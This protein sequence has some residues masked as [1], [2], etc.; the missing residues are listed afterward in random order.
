MM[1]RRRRT[2]RDSFESVYS[3]SSEG[4][5]LTC[6]CLFPCLLRAFSAVVLLFAAVVLLPVSVYMRGHPVSS[7]F[8]PPSPVLLPSSYL[9]PL[10]PLAPP[11]AP[12]LPAPASNISCRDKDV[13]DRK[14]GVVARCLVAGGSMP[15]RKCVSR[16]LAVV[17][18]GMN[19]PRLLHWPH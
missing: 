9:E 18:D 17:G 13:S 5:G 16:P 10:R 4:I 12:L 6:S 19:R 14:G 15:R 8:L 1:D 3:W 2:A 11:R 7:P